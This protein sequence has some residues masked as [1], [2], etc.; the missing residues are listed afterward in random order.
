MCLLL[1]AYRAHPDYPLVV[2]ANRDEFH[3]RK[4]EAAHWWEAP[5]IFAGR[6]LEAGGTWFG[7]D[8]AARFAAVT[9]YRD[10]PSNAA[11]APSRGR[12]PV[13][14]LTAESP[15]AM[16][17]EHERTGSRYNGYNLLFGS[18]DRVDYLTNRGLD[19]APLEPG[20][21]GLSNHVLDTPWPKVARGTELLRA[22]LDS[23]EGGSAEMLLEL[24][25]DRHAPADAQ[26][27]DTG[28][29]M[30]GE[31]LLSPMFI[32]SPRYGTRCSTV[33]L[34]HYSGSITVAER[35]FDPEGQML[36]QTVERFQ[37]SASS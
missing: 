35:R 10:P 37:A 15:Q 16:V 20:I 31:R 2:A 36:G 6:D 23:S 5:A 32:V 34:V 26:L 9:N 24:L 7:I 29:G 17:E 28:I 27:P 3:Q 22:C 25:Y 14:A 4:T 33:L 12:L 21:H 11:G 8:A 18:V 30:E 13:L 1:L 19:R